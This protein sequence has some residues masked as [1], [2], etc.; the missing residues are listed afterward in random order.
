QTE[1]NTV[2][3]T[4][5]ALYLPFSSPWWMLLPWSIYAISQRQWPMLITLVWLT[6]TSEL[7][8]LLSFG[9]YFIGQHSLVSWQHLKTHLKMN[10]RTIWMN[11]LPFHGAAWLLFI[12]FYFFWPRHHGQAMEEW[13]IFFIFL[14]CVSFPHVLAMRHVF[15]REK[16]NQNHRFN[17]RL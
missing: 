15:S 11:A 4:M 8:L 2:L 17:F 5:G 9:L 16:N 7:P 12:L 13:G 1:T 10:N 3:A 6:M 14:A